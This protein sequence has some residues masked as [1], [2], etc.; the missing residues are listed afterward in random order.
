MYLT[1]L[2]MHVLDYTV[3]IVRSRTQTMEFCFVFMTCGFQSTCTGLRAVL[4]N[5]FTFHTNPLRSFGT[6][7]WDTD[8][9]TRK[10][11]NYDFLLFFMRKC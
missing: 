1:I 8:R 9:R 3:G 5:Q 4:I 10:L 11:N 6:Q 2:Q 7:Y